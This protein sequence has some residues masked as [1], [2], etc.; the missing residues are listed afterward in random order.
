M[1]EPPSCRQ[2]KPGDFLAVRPLNWDEKI[3]EDDEDV[4][5]ADRGAPSGGRSHPR[6]GN[7]NDDGEVED[8][9]QG[10][11]TETRKGN[12]TKDGKKIAKGKAAAEGK[13]K[14]K[15]NGK[16]KDVVKQTPGGDDISGAAAL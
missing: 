10:G 2:Y 7:D 1:I 6:N 11:E 13:R 16:G 9:M 12:G 14:G 8:D 5:W 15:R 4:N 3:E